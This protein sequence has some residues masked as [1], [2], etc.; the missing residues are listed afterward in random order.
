MRHPVGGKNAHVSELNSDATRAVTVDND[1]IVVWDTERREW[2]AVM[3][4]LHNNQ[5]GG[6]VV[7]INFGGDDHYVVTASFNDMT[8]WIWDY[9]RG[10]AYCGLRGRGMCGLAEFS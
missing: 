10:K 1:Y 5:F 8:V 7:G 2:Q 4:N 3:K 6:G 9:R